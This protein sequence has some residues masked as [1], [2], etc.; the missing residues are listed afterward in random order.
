MESEHIAVH[1]SL[2]AVSRRLSTG[3]WQLILQVGDKAKI[4]K[5]IRDLNLGEIR[6]IDSDGKLMQ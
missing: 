5:P 2:S 3:Y 4:E 6:F 1:C